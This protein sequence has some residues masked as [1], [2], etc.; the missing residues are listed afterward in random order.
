M[1]KNL[2]LQNKTKPYFF[3]L[4][5]TKSSTKDCPYPETFGPYE[6]PLPS[7]FCQDSVSLPTPSTQS[8]E[9]R[10]RE[11][12]MLFWIDSDQN[13]LQTTE[14][15]R[16]IYPQLEIQ[17]APTFSEARSY[18]EQNLRDI[19]HR[20]QLLVICRGRY[21]QESKNVIDVVRLLDEFNL[22]VPIGLYTRDRVS[23]NRKIP[24][25]PER[26]QVFEEREELFTFVLD[27][28][29]Q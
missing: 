26:I 17:F 21:V 8:D 28:L 7:D 6:P 1:R 16:Q 29:I 22:S 18:L 9:N 27:N 5:S 4:G 2:P 12:P 3:F 10:S 19:R 25:I 13:D 11:N 23:L 15:L 20:Q 14:Q 24:N